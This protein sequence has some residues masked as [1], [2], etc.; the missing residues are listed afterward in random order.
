MKIIIEGYPY[1][2]EAVATIL[3][4]F[5]PSAK[6]DKISVDYVG[7]FYSKEIADCIFFCLKLFSMKRSIFSINPMSVPKT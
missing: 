3:K 4:G 6:N 5:E 7:Y 2:Q 1:P